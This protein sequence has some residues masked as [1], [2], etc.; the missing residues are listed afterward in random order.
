MNVKKEQNGTSLTFFLEGRLDTLGAPE[1]EKLIVS[2]LEGVTNLVLDFAKVDYVSSAGLR[3]L[4][5]I[6]QILGEKG[7]MVLQHVP[8]IVN[9]IF[10]VTGFQEY[11]KII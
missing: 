2:E 6:Q 1:C 10:E 7:E 3:L 4:I 11:V 8:D 9:E 5:Y